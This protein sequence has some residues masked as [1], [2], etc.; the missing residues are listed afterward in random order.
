M[1]KINKIIEIEKAK[2]KLEQLKDKLN[3][4][5]YNKFYE[6]LSIDNYR[7]DKYIN[8]NKK[9]EEMDQNNVKSLNKLKIKKIKKLLK[10][11]KKKLL[12]IKILKK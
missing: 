10:I 8:I 4:K 1:T 6:D 3:K 5:T 11:L 12:K 2:K 7:I 9:L